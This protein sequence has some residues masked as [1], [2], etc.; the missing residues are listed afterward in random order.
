MRTLILTL[1]GEARASKFSFF[2]GDAAGRPGDHGDDD[3]RL[4][5][6][7][8]ARFYDERHFFGERHPVARYSR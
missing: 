1:M 8:R 4:A 7:A 5:K 6:N 3:A 2:C